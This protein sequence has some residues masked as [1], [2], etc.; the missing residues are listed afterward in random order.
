MFILQSDLSDTFQ[1]GDGGAEWDALD[2]Q[3]DAVSMWPFQDAFAQMSST[4]TDS[5]AF[6]TTWNVTG[7]YDAGSFRYVTVTFHIDVASGGEVFIDWDDGNSPTSYTASGAVENFYRN[8]DPTA[9]KSAAVSITGD[10][11]RFYFHYIDPVTTSDSP[12]LLLSIDQWGDTAWSDMTD[13]FRSAENMQYMATDA[14][15][16]SSKPAMVDMFKKASSFDGDLSNWDVS[17][18]TSLRYLFNQATAFSGDGI[19]GWDVS[20]VTDMTHLFA[21]N[22]AFNAGISGWDVS[23]VTNMAYMFLQAHAFNADISGWDVSNVERMGQMFNGATAFNRDLSNWDVSKVT[24][25]FA[26]F[27]G[28]TAFNRDISNWD[29][30]SVRNMGFMFDGATAFN[31]NLGHWFIILEDTSV[32]N[33]ETVVTDIST[34]VAA[35]T[36]ID[37]Y[38]ITGTD[39][40]D[41][42]ITNGQLVLNSAADYSAKS[43]YYIT[44]VANSTIMSSFSNVEPSVSASIRVN[45]PSNS[46]PSVTSINR[47]DPSTQTTD[48]DTLQFKVTFSKTVSRVST[49][50]FE[51]SPGSPTNPNS[52]TDPVTSVTGSGSQYY[53]TVGSEQAGRY[54]L[55]VAQDN[56]IVDASNNSL[57]SHTPTDDDQSYVVTADTDTT[58]PVITLRGSSSVSVALGT[59]YT[60]AGATCNDDTD[61]DISSQIVVSNPVNTSVAQTYTVGYTCT[62]AASNSAHATRTVTVTADADTTDPVIALVGSSSVSV[63]LDSTYTD[64]GATCIDDTDGDISSQIVVS[65][66][67]NTSV[68]QTY[69]VTYTCTDAANN[70]AHA[71][72]TVT[73]SGSAPTVSSITRYNPSTQTTDSNTLQFEVTFS[74]AVTGVDADDFEMS[75]DSIG[76]NT[77]TTTTPTGSGQFTQTSSPGLPI[78][79]HGTTLDTITVP[80]SGTVASVSVAVDITHTFIGDLRVKLIAPN[81]TK[82]KTLHNLAGGSANDIDQTYTPDFGNDIEINGNWTLKIRDIAHPDT[83]TLNS[84]TLTIDYTD[85]STTTTTTNPVTSVTGSGSQYLVTVASEQEGTYNLDV[86]QD[87]DIVDASNNPLSSRTPTGDDQHYTVT[88]Q[89]DSTPP[90]ITL[91]GSSSV[92]VELGTTY[93]DAGATCSDDTDGDI[94]S[95]IVTSN[96]VDTNVAQTYTVEYACTDAASNSAHATRTVTVTAAADTTDPVITLAGS[97]SVSV[98][99][100]TTY[101]DAGATCSDDTDGD[102]SSQIVT[103]NPVDTNVAQTYTV[104]YACTDAASNSAHAT[105]TV[106]VTAAADTTDPVITL[107]G[108]S[109]VSVELGTT[110]T[111]AGATCSDDTDGDISSQIVTTNPVDTNVAQTYTVGYTCTDAAS[112]SAHATRTVTVTDPAPSVASITRHDPPTRNTNSSTLQF[113]VTF[114]EAVTGVGTDDFELSPQHRRQ[115]NNN[116]QQ[117]RPVH[118]DQFTQPASSYSADCI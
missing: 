77:T 2:A 87:N 104:E 84:W 17:S 97:S 49:D 113:E 26:M 5:D 20:K 6:V 68:A 61:G 65:N 92:S 106:T 116:Q 40:N 111:D 85:G 71:Y 91:A 118:P 55:D 101:T 58:D 108:S 64:A 89:A 18:M 35:D 21:D 47:H 62:D 25:M 1:A 66:P 96:P 28:A 103:S 80:D 9:S 67:V 7:A 63:G 15:N 19:S 90:V 82:T 112:N 43:R 32:D 75:P 30:S 23:K 60:D 45:S 94:S 102:I 56:N 59:T 88:F 69:T 44:I 107:A 57:S 51:L 50:D 114:S 34:R 10:L 46:A 76:G 74:E 12:E 33:G 100:G 110:Y 41:F 105:R 4:E 14:P 22:H 37:G 31:R 39:A 70:S 42:T 38:T 24:D 93:T 79:D 16:L 83:G 36:D 78:A 86:S 13:M 99:L 48:S 3:Y 11:K 27:N 98:E 29:V 54:N 52:Q 8:Y 73:V 81:D 115:H 95:Q 117:L 72:R 53:V 109:S